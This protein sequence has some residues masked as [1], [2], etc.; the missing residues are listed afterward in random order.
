MSQ[1]N[2]AENTVI[3]KIVFAF[4]LMQISVLTIMSFS[5]LSMVHKN[6]IAVGMYSNWHEDTELQILAHAYSIS[7]AEKNLGLSLVLQNDLNSS[8][9]RFIINYQD[10]KATH[11]LSSSGVHIYLLN[12][13]YDKIHSHVTPDLYFYLLRVI[14]L[15][16]TYLCFFY[17]FSAILKKMGLFPTII[18]LIT[19]MFTPWILLDSTSLFWSIPLRFAPIFYL[20]Y[21]IWKSV[22]FVIFRLKENLILFF[23]LIVSTFCGFEYSILVFMSVVII[24]LNLLTKTKLQNV[25]NLPVVFVTSTIVALLTWLFTLRFYFGNWTDSIKLFKYTF[26]KHWNSDDSSIAPIGGLVSGDDTVEFLQSLIRVTF[27]TSL[28]L[29]YDLIQLVS[30][31]SNQLNLLMKII[32]GGT[33]FG[34]FLLIIVFRSGPKLLTASYISVYIIWIFTI[35]SYVFHHV[36]IIGTA[37]ILFLMVYLLVKNDGVNNVDL[38]K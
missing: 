38:G 32:I 4:F 9:N 36:H 20:S 17:L 13:I 34:I 12:Y 35:K 27:K 33:S 22:N 26:F 24:Y 29:P 7:G 21:L 18:V 1:K 6:N 3:K 10:F 28:L 37:L 14:N 16:L 15:S 25:I 2:H 23:T 19:F 11:Y 30:N 8:S 5:N 31:Q